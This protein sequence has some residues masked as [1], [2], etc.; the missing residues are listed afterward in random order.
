MVGKNAVFAG[1][2]D[3]ER[4]GVGGGR[5]DEMVLAKS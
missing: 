5:F 1:V 2:P 3:E 4:A